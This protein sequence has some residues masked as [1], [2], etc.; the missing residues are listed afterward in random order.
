MTV[1]PVISWVN[2]YNWAVKTAHVFTILNSESNW[3]SLT[4]T[5]N[6]SLVFLAELSECLLFLQGPAGEPM[7]NVK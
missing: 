5:S 3:C 6:F 7:G 4:V 2:V 1:R